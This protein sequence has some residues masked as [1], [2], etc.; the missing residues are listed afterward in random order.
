M[1]GYQPGINRV[2]K[3]KKGQV[4]D[5]ACFLHLL[6]DNRRRITSVA[7]TKMGETSPVE[8]LAF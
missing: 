6:Q 2:F 4:F 8:S 3:V 1:L 7:W 5:G